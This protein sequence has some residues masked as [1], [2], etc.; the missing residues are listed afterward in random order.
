[1]TFRRF[2]KQFLGACVAAGYC[3]AL[4]GCSSPDKAYVSGVVTVDGAPAEGYVLLFMPTDGI[5]GPA[6]AR[7]GPGGKYDARTS[8]TIDW[9]VPGTFRIEVLGP[10]E[11]ARGSGGPPPPGAV[12]VPKR[13]RGKVSELSATIEPGENTLNFELDLKAI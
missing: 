8:R 1:M 11:L 13:Y 2:S 10:V 6:N 3:L 12:R 5:A 4:V 9:V 7:T